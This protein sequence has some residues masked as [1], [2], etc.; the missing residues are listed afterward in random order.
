MM[1]RMNFVMGNVCDSL[2]REEKHGKVTGTC[3]QDV[4]KVGADPK[5]NSCNMAE[6][7]RWADYEDFEEAVDDIGGGS[8]VDEAIGQW[9]GF[10]HPRNQRDFGNRTTG[11]FGQRENFHSVGGHPDLD[12]DLDAIKLKI[13]PFQGKNNPDA[14]LEWEK[15]VDWIFDCHNYSK[16]KKVKLIVIE[17]TDYALIWWDQ[18][19]ISR[20]R[21]GE[22][23]VASWEEMKVL[24]RRRFVPN[25]Y[26]RDLYLKLQGLNQGSRSM[27]KYFK[28]IKIA[29]IQANLIE[30]REATMA[31]FLYE[32][33][34]DIANVVELQHCVE[35][36]DMVHMA[37]R[38]RVK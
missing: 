16:A 9:E 8:F 19:V 14:Y 11:Q 7:P 35:L 25:H 21:S 4:R 12:G 6:R 10:R 24:M 38:W 36:K 5:S 32:L 27:D 15:K 37:R 28:K 1:E 33:N 13:P 34:R 31:G 3:T 26:Y 2:D 29:M 23:P 18:N 20:R 22:R 17:F 30:D